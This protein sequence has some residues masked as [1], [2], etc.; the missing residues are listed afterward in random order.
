MRNTLVGAIFSD[1]ELFS[2][3]ELT[4][5]VYDRLGSNGRQFPLDEKQI[6]SEIT[7]AVE[8]L[9]HEV[10]GNLKPLTNAELAAV[11]SEIQQTYASPIEVKG[12]LE[13][14]TALYL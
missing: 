3:L 6:V 2:N 12:L 10:I 11:V 4:Q 8:D 5:C 7:G 9:T 13:S 14:I 1:C